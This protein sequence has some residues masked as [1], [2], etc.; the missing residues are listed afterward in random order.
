MPNIQYDLLTAL[1]EIFVL[2]MAMLI[3]LLDL[4]LKSNTR[5]LLYIFSQLTLLGAAFI[6]ISTHTASVTYAFSGMF[7]DDPMADVLKLMIYLGTSVLLVYSRNYISLRG[8]FRGEFYAL[9]LFAMAGMMIMV[10][11]QNFLT[12]YMG[13][14]LLSLCLYSL[15]ALDRDNPRATE[16]A[17]KYFVLGALASGMLLY[18]MSMI[19]GMTGSLN[20]A[21]IS[22]ALLNGVPD[23]SVLILGLVFIVAGLAFKLGAVPF[24]MWVPDVYQGAPTA[25]TLLIGSVPKLAAFAFVIRILAQGLFVLA[26]DWQGMLVIMAVL[27]IAIGNITAIAQTNIKRMLAYSTISHIGFLLFGLMSVSMN[28]YASAM[29]YVSSYLLMTLAA[30]G[31]IML[32]SRQGF[33]AENLDDL[34]GLNQR[35][36]W[37]AFLML[38]V[39]FSMAGVPPTLGFYA[40]FTVLQA[41][42]HAG[43]VWLVVF[44]V[45][46]A[47][48]G[49]FYYLRVVKLM[50]FDEPEDH[51][52]ILSNPEMSMVLSVNAVGLLILGLMPQR[53]MDICA[54]AMVRS[55]Q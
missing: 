44:A 23:R 20:I 45:L 40:K 50:Y 18:G 46:M 24:Q 49:A 38:I 39:M 51:S 27:S 52:K 31:I 13:L 22:S 14:E 36:P 29:F 30:F 11:G 37:Y 26:V 9:V 8:M 42:L 55:L 48:V 35:S 5:I 12:L 4:F 6:T 28:G 41:A 7:V 2:S 10:S 17:M 33:E 47:A 19:Y 34:K 53:L 25:V 15:V 21:Q 32:L 3:L 54:Y 1:P 16:A 43:F